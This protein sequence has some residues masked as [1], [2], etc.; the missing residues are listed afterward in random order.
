MSKG[1][2]IAEM[3][4]NHNTARRPGEYC[5]R[6]ESNYCRLIDMPDGD[7]MCPACAKEVLGELKD[8]EPD[9]PLELQ[10]F[11]QDADVI[12]DKGVCYY[13][14]KEH[15]VLYLSGP[16]GICKECAIKQYNGEI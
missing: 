9:T 12:L 6:C 14:G 2:E 13:C 1:L 11:L 3:M 15:D 7:R 5:D 16:Y 4:D 10:Y 8:K